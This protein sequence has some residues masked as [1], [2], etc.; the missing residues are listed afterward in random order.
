MGAYI[1]PDVTTQIDMIWSGILHMMAAL[2]IPS[3][4][5]QRK[6]VTAYHTISARVRNLRWAYAA[7]LFIGSWLLLAFVEA[8]WMF[9]KTF[10]PSLNSYVAARFLALRPD[11][12][13]ES[14]CGD[15]SAN[16]KLHEGF[17]ASVPS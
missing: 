1:Q 6:D 5:T 15:A 7:W 11:L 8:V 16:I 12:A 2:V 14:P 17:D 10:S 13:E 4:S 9:R 3:L